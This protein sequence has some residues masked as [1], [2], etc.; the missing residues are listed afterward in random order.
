MAPEPSSAHW[1]RILLLWGCGVLAAMQ[2]AKIS[3][4]FQAMQAAYATSPAT[5]GLVLSTVGLVGLVFG[6][7]VGVFAHAFGYRRLLLVG[8][9]LGSGMSLAQSL[10][11][12]L[13]L[14]FATRVLEGASHLA[15]V[16]AA[17]TLIVAHSGP[18]QR[19]IAMGLWSTFVGVGFALMA[20]LGS[21]AIA[22]KGVGALMLLHAAAMAVACAVAGSVLHADPDTGLAPQRPGLAMLWRQHVQ[23]YTHVATALPGLCFFCYTVLSVALMTFLPPFAGADRSWLAVVLPLMVTSGTFCAGWLAQYW[24]SPLALVRMA[25]A[26]VALAGVAVW[27]C[28]QAGVAIAPAALVLMFLGGMSGGAGYALIP[29]LSDEKLLQGRANGAVA[30]MGNL[31]ST[32]GPPL[33][34]ALMTPWG[35]TGMALPVVAFAALGIALATWGGKRHRAGSAST[36]AR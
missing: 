15:V 6:V 21:M 31:G 17:P 12:P 9:A 27:L 4:A 16:V 22:W 24:T 32:S 7:T 14:L 23:I 11:L 35:F 19:S 2:F 33:L 1:P 8:L 13:P 26:G 36:A 20:V 10:L 28:F 29:Y 18:G 3:V 30:Q 25:H 5:M 34:A